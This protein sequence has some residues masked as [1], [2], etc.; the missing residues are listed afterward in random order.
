MNNWCICWFFT[1]FLLGILIFKRLTVRHLYKFGVKGLKRILEGKQLA[2]VLAVM[3]G[4]DRGAVCVCVCVL[5]S[6]HRFVKLS[7]AAILLVI[8]MISGFHC[9][10]D[11]ICALLGCYAASSDNFLM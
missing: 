8:C 11:K 1:Q 6:T 4:M 3:R 5:D 10:G 9:K 7:F 2:K